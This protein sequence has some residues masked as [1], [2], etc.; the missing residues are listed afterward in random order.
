MLSKLLGCLAL[1]TG[2]VYA[3]TQ[4]SGGPPAGGFL[5]SGGPPVEGFVRGRVVSS[6]SHGVR[7]LKDQTW[8]P[9][10][11]PLKDLRAVH[12]YRDSGEPFDRIGDEPDLVELVEQIDHPGPHWPQP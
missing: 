6:P 9:G 12:Q 10:G 5:D 11:M 8:R 2:M 3:A 1:G 4:Y 7:D